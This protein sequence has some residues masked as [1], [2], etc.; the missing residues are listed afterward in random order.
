MVLKYTIHHHHHQE[1]TDIHAIFDI[2]TKHVLWFRQ[3]SVTSPLNGHTTLL[4]VRFFSFA[5]LCIRHP[6]HLTNPNLFSSSRG[7]CFTC[8]ISSTT[9]T[10]SPTYAITPYILYLSHLTSSH[11]TYWS[12]KLDFPNSSRAHLNYRLYTDFYSFIPCHDV[13]SNALILVLCRTDQT[14]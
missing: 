7:V 5:G 6:S 9:Y 13:A 8:H 2:G 11:P 10:L 14:S 3:G 4:S 12:V 1:D